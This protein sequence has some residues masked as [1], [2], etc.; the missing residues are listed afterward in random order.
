MTEPAPIDPD[1]EREMRRMKA[2]FPF[3]IV[4]G[5]IGEDGK[6]RVLAHFNKSGMNKAA[7]KGKTVYCLENQK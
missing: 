6:P 1:L 3:R 7:R 2:Y 4:W 5:Y